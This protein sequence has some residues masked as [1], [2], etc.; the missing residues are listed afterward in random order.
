MVCWFLQACMPSLVIGHALI[1]TSCVRVTGQM[2]PLQLLLGQLLTGHI[3][4]GSLRTYVT[5]IVKY[6]QGPI[7]PSP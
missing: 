1:S 4:T 2:S 7:S 5:S 3:V 6:S